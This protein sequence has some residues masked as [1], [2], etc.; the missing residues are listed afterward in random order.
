MF[1]EQGTY[2]GPTTQQQIAEAKA[3]QL[4]SALEEKFVH[5]HDAEI[6]ARVTKALL[7]LGDKNE[8]APELK[9]LM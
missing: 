4:V 5:G 1:L 6:K 9:L 8:D 2:Y 3:G 7:D